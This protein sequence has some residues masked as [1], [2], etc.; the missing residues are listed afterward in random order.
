MLEILPSHPRPE[1]AGLASEARERILSRSAAEA[2]ETSRA[3]AGKLSFEVVEKAKQDLSSEL[4]PLRARGIVTL[5]KLVRQ[6]HLQSH[7]SKWTSRVH[8]LAR[9]FS[10]HLHDV[11]SYVFLAAVQ[12][13]VALADGSL[14]VA[15]LHW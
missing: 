7:N 13:L 6:S 10:A 11:E 1:A 3:K 2:R 9:V 5:T 4:V 14:D 15:I 8:I 12:G